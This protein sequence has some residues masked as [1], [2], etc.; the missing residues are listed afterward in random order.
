MCACNKSIL[1]STKE[2]GMATIELSRW[3]T[4]AYGC[5]WSAVVFV[6]V[7]PNDEF[8]DCERIVYFVNVATAH[9]TL[10]TDKGKNFG[11]VRDAS[12]FKYVYADSHIN[13]IQ[14]SFS[15]F[16]S[17]TTPH[18]VLTTS[19]C[20]LFNCEIFPSII[21]ASRNDYCRTI[22]SKRNASS[23]KMV[24]NLF[25]RSILGGDMRCNKTRINKNHI[26]Y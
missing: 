7:G 22:K 15:L 10:A 23:W 14:H 1:N 26:I 3:R 13:T 4:P 11:I 6:V 9:A 16:C 21:N 20:I 8:S 17:S 25:R 5:W 24:C 18:F 19:Y 12:G 2:N